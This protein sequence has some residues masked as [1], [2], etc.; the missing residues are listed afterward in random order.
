MWIDRLTKTPLTTLPASIDAGRYQWDEKIGGHERLNQH[1]DITPG[2]LLLSDGSDR[3]Q[4]LGSNGSFTKAVID[5][6]ER[7]TLFQNAI[8]T[9]GET[10][11][12]QQTPD[13]PLL[14]PLLPAAVIDAELDLLPVEKMLQIVLKKGHLHEIAHHPRLDIRYIEETTDVARAKRL[15]KGALVHLASH[16]ECWQRQTLSGVV[17]KKVKARFSE[18]DYQIYENRVF[19]RLVDKLSWHLNSRIRTVEQ[20]K[21]TLDDALGFEEGSGNIDYRVSQKI[22]VLWGQTFDAAA[23]LQALELLEN[24]LQTLK[25]MLKSITSLRQSGLYLMIP[26]HAQVGA[27]L[28]R[29]NILNHDAH[30][31]HLAILWDQL[32]R[33]QQTSQLTP[34]Q[35]FTQQRTLAAHYSRYAGLV[36]QHALAG[37]PQIRWTASRSP[38]QTSGTAVAEFDYAWAGQTLRLQQHGFDWRL[39][40]V[41]PEQQNALKDGPQVLLELIPWFGF[42]PTPDVTAPMPDNRIILWPSIDGISNEQAEAQQPGWYALSPM[43]LYCIERIGWLIDKTLNKH[44]TRQYA[45]PIEKI[46]G[47]AAELTRTIQQNNQQNSS[48]S[49]ELKGNPPQLRLLQVLE[50]QEADGLMK[51]LDES[52][53]VNQANQLLKQQ[54]AIAAL[55]YCPVCG[56]RARLNHQ[57]PAGFRIECHSCGTARYLEQAGE[58]LKIHFRDKETSETL[59]SGFTARGRW[60]NEAGKR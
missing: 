27:T 57:P 24:T 3:Y 15:A 56:N 6:P 60:A 16:S 17:P 42:S 44:L 23:T 29:T 39:S 47:K 59:D 1:S 52:N 14:S 55:S 12:K 45:K 54:R 4:L 18:D 28:H 49:L 25:E 2:G 34:A 21:Q 5:N 36:A 8:L 41:T 11:A 35:R 31:R 19:A 32:N 38:E 53:A 30:Y 51:A 48:L 58:A 13:Q 46:P 50:Q 40:L 9:L 20:L 37:N 26:R 7:I 22:C 43:D 10:L 33:L